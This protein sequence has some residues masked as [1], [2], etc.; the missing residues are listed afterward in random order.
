MFTNLEEILFKYEI[1]EVSA[2]TNGARYKENYF[3]NNIKLEEFDYK[4]TERFIF[5][6]SNS[7]LEYNQ[8]Y[9]LEY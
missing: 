3:N 8:I 7:I 6:E 5:D 1:I 2:D 9:V 4:F